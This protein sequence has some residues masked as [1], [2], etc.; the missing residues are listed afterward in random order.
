VTHAELQAALADA[1]ITV[2]AA[3]AHGRLCG[4]LCTRDG[5]DAEQWA[6][7]LAG[8]RRES[9]PKLPAELRGL[10]ASTH[11]ILQSDAFEFEPLLPGDDAPL[12]ERVSALAAWCDGFLYGV[13]SGAPDPGVVATGEVGEFLGDLADIARAE[14]EPGRE[15]EAGEGD[16]AELFEF[17]RAGAQLTFDEL[18]AARADA[19][20]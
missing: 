8:D 12:G 13:G 20:R 19:P 4:A 11:E 3:E 14:L 5:Y 9:E 7:E 10:P 2:D 1:D 17:V 6:A 16:Y 18:A 15:G